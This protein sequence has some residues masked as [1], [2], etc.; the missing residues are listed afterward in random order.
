MEN[1]DI[2]KYL[3]MALRRKWWVIIPFLLTILAGLYYAMITPKIYEAQTLIL[4][5]AQK[6]PQDYVRE[7]VSTNV[8]D[9]L[10]T[11]TQQVTSRTNLEKIIQQLKLYTGPGDNNMILEGKVALFRERITIDIARGGSGGNA[12]SISFS[13]EI[14]KNAMG[15]AN[16]LASNFI[17][18]NLKIRESQALGTSAFLADE[19]ES[20]KRRL[21]EKE[22]KLKIYREKFMGGLPEQLQTNLSILER[23]QAQLDQLHSN[24]RDSENR[25]IIIQQ[26]TAETQQSRPNARIYLPAQGEEAMDFSA[27]KNQLAALEAKYTQKYPDV[28]RLKKMIENLKAEQAGTDSGEAGPDSGTEV[29]RAVLTEVDQALKRQLQ[30]IKSEIQNIKAQIRKANS[31]IKWHQAKVEETPK[32]EQELLSLR[33]DYENLKELYNSLLNRKL[34]AEISVSMEKKQKGEQFRVVD[35][36]KIPVRPAKPDI[37]KIILMTLALGLGLGGGLAYL[38]EIMDTSYK[39]PDDVEKELD[40]PILVSIPFR[41]TDRELRLTKRKQRMA[42]ASVGV[43]FVLSAI[44]IVLAT[45]GLDPT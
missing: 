31:Q 19:L 8:E 13:D 3:D 42:Y 25:K 10:R 40:M 15:V 11:I 41:Y 6:V 9:R 37:R 32:R 27:L 45:K 29:E 35:S 4:V 43:G 33:R 26:R 2:T 34:E 20:T 5:Q 24:L 14:P 16:A 36:A 1:F 7:I 44:G 22:N 12:F 38:T 23:L 30:D 28:I 17:S 21:I 39:T 18:E